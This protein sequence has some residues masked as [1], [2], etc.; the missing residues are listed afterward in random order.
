MFFVNYLIIIHLFHLFL[1]HLHIYSYV[2]TSH[3][4]LCKYPYHHI[5]IK[6][7]NTK[8][9][10]KNA[11][12]TDTS[13]DTSMFIHKK[14]S[15]YKYFHLSTSMH[16]YINVYIYTLH[17]C[18]PGSGASGTG[19]ADVLSKIFCM[20]YITRN[21]LSEAEIWGMVSHNQSVEI[22]E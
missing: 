7:Y 9:N 22:P 10:S 3:I 17:L 12:C 15:T 6:Y 4:Y 5:S 11:V 19:N 16:L 21:G 1:T 13:I 18:I 2:P 14:I 8:N 20:V